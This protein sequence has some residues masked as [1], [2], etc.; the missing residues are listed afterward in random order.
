MDLLLVTIGC[1]SIGRCFLFKLVGLVGL[2]EGFVDS[3]FPKRVQMLLEL[4]WIILVP[5]VNSEIQTT[6][7]AVAVEFNDAVHVK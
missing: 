5:I 6:P 7:F 2:S 4:V 3:L 1:E